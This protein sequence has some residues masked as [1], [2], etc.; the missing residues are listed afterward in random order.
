MV[1][2]RQALIFIFLGYFCIA[3]N[4]VPEKMMEKG[5]HL[6]HSFRGFN[7]WLLGPMGFGHNITV[8]E[9][10][11]GGLGEPWGPDV[12]FKEV[13]SDSHPS[14][15]P[16]CLYHLPQGVPPTMDQELNMGAHGGKGMFK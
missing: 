2:F 10:C 9:V 14:A 12:T 11:G 3:L 6:P 16:P 4:N 13:T 1:C 5:K 7:S 8:I 15:R